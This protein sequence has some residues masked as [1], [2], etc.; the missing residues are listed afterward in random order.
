MSDHAAKAQEYRDRAAA[1]LTAGAA[2]TLEQVREKHARAAQVWTEMADAEEA[3]LADKTAR[4]Q[5]AAPDD[6]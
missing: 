2:T 6:A 3:R 1:E 5:A 4:A